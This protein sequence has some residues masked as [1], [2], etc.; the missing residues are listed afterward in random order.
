[1]ADIRIGTSG[2]AYPSWRGDFFP[3]GLRQ[4]DELS[5]L[6]DRVTSLEANATFYSLQKPSTFRR[7]REQVRPEVD[8]AL[9][10][11]RYITHMLRLRTIDQ[12]L[13]NFW[14]SG[15]LELGTMLGPV[16]W[17]LPASFPFDARVLA[18]FLER[19]PRSMAEAAELA[20][21]HDDRVAEASTEAQVNRPIRHAL[22]PR[23]PSFRDSTALRLLQRHDVALVLTDGAGLVTIDADTTDFRYARLHGHTKLYHSGYAARSLDAWAQRVREWSADHEA[24]HVYFDNDAQGRAPHDAVA[25]LDRL[26]HA[27]SPTG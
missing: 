8:I 7:W 24:V 9:K 13:A 19:L 27:A 25:L 12:A 21:G 16:L 6:A 4:R 23:H 15:P 3:K 1:M 14:A 22:E 18:D 5:Y 26:T 17:Q 11:S 20:R 10:G 2:W